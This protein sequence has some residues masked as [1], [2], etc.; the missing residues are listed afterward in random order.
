M[1]ARCSLPGELSMNSDPQ[2]GGRATSFAPAALQSSPRT[3]LHSLLTTQ[4]QKQE[5]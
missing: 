3:D 4:I 1:P 2:L 5:K